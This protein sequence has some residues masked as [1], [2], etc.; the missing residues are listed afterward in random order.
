MKIKIDYKNMK[1][2]W[3]SKSIIKKAAYKNMN[4]IGRERWTENNIKTTA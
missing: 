4:T 3:R 1:G 2:R